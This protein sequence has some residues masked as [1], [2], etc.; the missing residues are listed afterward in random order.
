[1][2][3]GFTNGPDLLNTVLNGSTSQAAFVYDEAVD[4]TAIGAPGSFRLLV[5]NGNPISGISQGGTS[6]D[7]K[8]VTI[9]FP[10]SIEAGVGVTTGLG[11]TQDRVGNLQQYTSV[12]RAETTPNPNATPP[13]AGGHGDDEAHDPPQ[14]R[15]EEV[16][17]A[18]LR[19]TAL[20]AARRAHRQGLEAAQVQEVP[21]V[22][23]VHDPLQEAPERPGP[24]A[25]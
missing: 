25:G 8:T 23:P 9:G 16:R 7:R 19:A 10:G 2:K 20:Q 1:M 13:P 5:P 11:A 21:Q 14:A 12:S 17:R 4:P 18:G 3:P 6:S 15:L 24:R 22:G